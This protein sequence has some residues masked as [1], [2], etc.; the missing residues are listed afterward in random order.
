MAGPREPE[1]RLEDRLAETS[2]QLAEAIEQQAATSQ[3]LAVIGR[4]PIVASTGVVG[5]LKDGTGGSLDEQEI[6]RIARQRILDR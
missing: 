6:E 4:V 5:V 1:A 3:I 2:R